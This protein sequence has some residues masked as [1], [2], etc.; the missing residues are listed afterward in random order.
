[1]EIKEIKEVFERI[2]AKTYTSEKGANY[3]VPQSPYSFLRAIGIDK[4]KYDDIAIRVKIG[5]DEKEQLIYDC[6]QDILGKLADV[7][8]LNPKMVASV[9]WQTEVFAPNYGREK[10]AKSYYSNVERAKQI[11]E[12]KNSSP[13][14]ILKND[15]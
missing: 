6:V 7:S 15:D 5:L 9:K 13:I 12:A 4:L 10:Q 1:M 8:L 14:N 2:M 11:Q 3:W